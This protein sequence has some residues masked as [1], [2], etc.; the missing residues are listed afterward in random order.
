MTAASVIG[1]IR[2]TYGTTA[3]RSLWLNGIDDLDASL[4]LELDQLEAA[5]HNYLRTIFPSDVPVDLDAIME[6]GCG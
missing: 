4:G 3:L 5:W 1:F 6:S 2:N